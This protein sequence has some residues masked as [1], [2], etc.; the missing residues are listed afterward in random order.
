MRTACAISISL[1]AGLAY[2]QGVIFSVTDAKPLAEAAQLFELRYGIPISYEDP[3]Y[4]WAGELGD[5]T[6]PEFAK[7]HPNG[8]RGLYLKGSRTLVLRGDPHQAVRSA[9]DA[10]PLLQSLVDDHLKAGYPRQFKLIPNG[11]GIDIVPTAVKNAAGILVADESLLETRITLPELQRTAG[12][13]L[14]AICEAIRT[15]TGKNI[16]VASNQFQS[17][18]W[19]VTLGANNEPART[20]LQR[21]LAGLHTNSA[22]AQIPKAAWS[23]MYGP[24]LKIYLLNVR[25][26]VAEVPSPAGKAIKRPV[27]R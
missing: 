25:Q 3:A 26:V 20:V 5:A 27:F 1:L 17:L 2:G 10:M 9:S 22:G 12:Q 15:S 19:V 24:G 4:S 18:Y 6:D 23:L 7:S 8:L 14:D 13:T 11:D 16:G 21:T